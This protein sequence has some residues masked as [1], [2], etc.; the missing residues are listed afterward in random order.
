MSRIWYL[1]LVL[2]TL[3]FAIVTTPAVAQDEDAAENAAVQPE[4]QPAEGEEVEGDELVATVRVVDGRKLVKVRQTEEEEYVF[5]KVGMTLKQGADIWVGPKSAVVL[6]VP[7]D[8]LI[9]VDRA[10]KVKLLELRRVNDKEVVT[11][12]GILEGRAGFIATDEFVTHDVEIKGPSATNATRG[13]YKMIHMD[14]SFYGGFSVAEKTKMLVFN[15]NGFNV[16]VGDEDSFEQLPSDSNSVAQYQWDL[17]ANDPS[18]PRSRQLLEALLVPL[19]AAQGGV[20]YSRFTGDPRDGVASTAFRNSLAEL[21]GV[22]IPSARL[23]IIMSWEGNGDVDLGILDPDGFRL[24]TDDHFDA[25]IVT[26]SPNG[27]RAGPDLR[28]GTLGREWIVYPV[29]NP[30]AGNFQV[31]ANY[32]SGAASNFTIEV[33]KDGALVGNHA[34]T[35]SVGTPQSLNT[36]NVP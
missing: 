33:Y 23:Q 22:R 31:D 9:T 16:E 26:N 1:A 15:D 34:G 29:A 20:D 11:K 14:S 2:M 10:T 3:S 21:L 30:P 5:A 12:V 25:G 32:Y 24:G 4:E 8:Q 19:Y 27:G 6:S 35:V 17:T 7:P 28:K 13:T 36:I 18:T